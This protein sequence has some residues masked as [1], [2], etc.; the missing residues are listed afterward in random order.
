[1]NTKPITEDDLH[2]YVDGLLDENRRAEVAAYFETHPHVAARFTQY[3]DH[4]ALIRSALELVSDEPVPTRLNLTH[5]MKAP[6]KRTPPFWQ[7]AAAAILLLTTGGVGGWGLHGALRVPVEGVAALTQEA[8]DS[9]TTFASDPLR[10]VEL[11]ADNTAELV[12]WASN[13]I[14]RKPVLPD[15][16]KSGYRMMGGRIIST[17]HGAGLMLMYDNDRGNR[18]VMLSRPM[19]IDQNRKMTPHSQGN[20]DGWGWASS[21]M[22]Y[23]LTGSL[24]LDELHPLAD[25]IRRQVSQQT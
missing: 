18:L 2:A 24:P 3:G 16:S 21:G 23:S 6:R 15:L 8:A 10:P 12:E 9:F 19:A 5:I 25:D 1:M 20:I 4:R 7:S 11:R 17:P 22:G 14:G 13:R